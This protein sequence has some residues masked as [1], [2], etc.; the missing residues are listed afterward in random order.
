MLFTGW[1]VR[2]EKNI[3]STS[4]KRPEAESREMFLR[5]STDRLSVQ[6]GPT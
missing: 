3:L 4:Q 6:Y 5:S 2:T 1:E